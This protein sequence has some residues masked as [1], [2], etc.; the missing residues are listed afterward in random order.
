MMKA[1]I[2]GESRMMRGIYPLGKGE[3]KGNNSW[4]RHRASS[5]TRRLGLRREPAL[6]SRLGEMITAQKQTVGL[7]TGT[8]YAPPSFPLDRM[9]QFGH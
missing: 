8:V 5:R 7:N 9:V 2:H 1:T 6:H 3:A 4:A